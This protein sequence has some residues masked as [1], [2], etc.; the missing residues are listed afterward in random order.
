VA[1]SVRIHVT[2]GYQA[3]TPFPK[4]RKG[5]SLIEVLIVITI[6]AILIGVLLPNLNEARLK[7]RD[8]KRKADLRGFAQ[9]L[10]TYK[11]NQSLP[12]YPDPATIPAPGV[13]WSFNSITYMKMPTDP[14]YGSSPT[15]HFYRYYSDPAV[16]PTTYY[17]GACLEDVNDPDVQSAPP[18]GTGWTNCST[19]TWYVKSEP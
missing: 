6:I 3:G 9:A 19:L 15:T 18:T 7:A 17:I 5:F 12:S 8:E 1:V 4:N 14:L 13:V 2:M 10:E 16:D 11:I